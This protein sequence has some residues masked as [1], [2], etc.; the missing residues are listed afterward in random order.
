M[1][2][3]MEEIV[4]DI[5]KI[6][7]LLQLPA[8]VTS[9]FIQLNGLRT[10]FLVAGAGEPIVMVHGAGPGASGWTGWREAVPV[11]AK[12]FKVYLLDT[13]GFGLTDKPTDIVYRDQASVNH[14][15]SFIDAM[16]LDRVNLIGNS[17]G[18]Y[19]AA[20]YSVDYPHRVLRALLVSSGSIAAAMGID[21]TAAQSTGKN[22]LNSYDGTPESMR[23]WMKI[24]V[25]DHSK[26]TDELVAQ[27]VAIA[28][29]PGHT[30]CIKSQ[31]EYRKSLKTN[32]NELQLFELRHRLP[33]LTT[34]M[35]M[36]WGAKDNF[37]PPEF[38]NMLRDLLP[39]MT[40]DLLEQSGHQA[41]NDESDRFN[42]IAMRFLGSKIG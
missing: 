30:Y 9:N 37:A 28:S 39:N 40:F 14:L 20:K 6:R 34:P 33:Q 36:V 22:V 27:R 31:N 8:G 5:E 16:C 35:H 19:I 25:N 12:H 21:R 32:P 18:A 42:D 3:T 1:I 7:S 24:I 38:A 11:L 13:L 23:E 10:H 2:E 15:A 26:I 29:L 4:S 17:R 41:Q